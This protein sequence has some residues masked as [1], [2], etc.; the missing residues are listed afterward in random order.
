MGKD[1]TTS[2][3]MQPVPATPAEA[4]GVMPGARQIWPSPSGS[5]LPPAT[6]PPGQ[7]YPQMKVRA[8][9]DG[10]YDN[11]MRRTGDVFWIRGTPLAVVIERELE[12]MPA[13]NPIGLPVVAA[14]APGLTKKQQLQV[15]AH[16]KRGSGEYEGREMPAAFSSKWMQP[17]DDRTPER[18]TTNNEVIR[19]Q[20]DETLGSHTQPGI[21]TDVDVT[22]VDDNPLGE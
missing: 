12:N 3:P 5:D 20:H 19:Q 15:Q 18:V 2:V 7:K 4:Q 13:V 22:G 21:Q 9:K 8:I 16:Q 1:K 11:V 10:Y 14:D 6:R 17:V